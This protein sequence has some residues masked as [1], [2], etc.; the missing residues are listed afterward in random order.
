ML[1]DLLEASGRELLGFIAKANDSGHPI[2]APILGDDDDLKRMPP[3]EFELLIGFGSIRPNP[4]R[5]ECFTN[6]KAMGFSFATVVHPAAV[7]AASA[8]LGKGCQVL[9]GAIVQ[10][11]AVLGENIIVNTKASIDHDSRVGAHTHLA[12]GVTVC[13][14]VQIGENCLIGCGASVIQGRAIGAGALVSAGA[15]VIS[16]VSAGAVV[17]GVPAK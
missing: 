9:A 11:G 3:E 6:L 13:G 14:G 5:G 15:V 7:V 1:A 2:G 8:T 4:K 17:R 10:N 16:D 12:P